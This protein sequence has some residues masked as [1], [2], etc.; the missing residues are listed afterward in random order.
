MSALQERVWAGR[1]PLEIRLASSE[2]R[3]YDQSDPYLVS[4]SCIL[5]PLSRM[6]EIWRTQFCL[7]LTRTLL[8]FQIQV[9]MPI[10]MATVQ[11]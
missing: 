11:N 3:I 9:Q 5:E 7:I 6:E 10:S 8:T 2:C 1:L 4:F